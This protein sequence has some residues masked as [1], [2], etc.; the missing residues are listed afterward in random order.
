[1]PVALLYFAAV[2]DLLGIGQEELVLPSLVVTVSDLG[3]FLIQRYPS[4]EGRLVGVRFA[5]N[6]EFAQPSQ[7]LRSGDTIALIPPTAGG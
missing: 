6:E 2:R 3:D 5:V 7:I 1:M 4:L